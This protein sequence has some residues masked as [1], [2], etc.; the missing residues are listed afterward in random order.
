VYRPL[1]S[2][3]FARS[4]FCCTAG[5]SEKTHSYGRKLKYV[6]LYNVH[7]T[8]DVSI[9]N[10]KIVNDKPNKNKGDNGRNAFSDYVQNDF[11]FGHWSDDRVFMTQSLQWDGLSAEGI[12]TPLFIQICRKTSLSSSEK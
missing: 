10:K 7:T 4:E 9:I 11:S 6:S 12:F 8:D 2:R 1:E 3:I 5:R